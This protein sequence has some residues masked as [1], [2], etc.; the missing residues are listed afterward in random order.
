[1]HTSLWT[2]IRLLAW[3]EG[4][5]RS[6]DIDSPRLT[7]EILLSHV[8]NIR[9]L[10]LYLQFDRP[11]STNEL[12]LYKALIK[13]RVEK[14]PV[15]YITGVKG[16]WNSQFFVTPDV[17]IPRPDTETLVESA[18]ALVEQ[19][20]QAM[21]DTVGVQDNSGKLISMLGKDIYGEKRL[22][23][24]ELGTGSGAVII[25]LAMANPDVLFYATDISPDATAVAL[26]NSINL[27]VSNDV[28]ASNAASISSDLSPSD[29][30][31]KLSSV[32]VPVERVGLANLFFLSGSWFLPIK[33]GVCFDLI[34][35]NPPYIPTSDIKNLQQEV[36]EYE[37]VLALDGGVEGISCLKE[38]LEAAPDYLESDG[39]LLI[40]MGFDQKQRLEHEVVSI[41]KYDKPVF[42]KDYAGHHRVVSLQKK[43]KN[44]ENKNKI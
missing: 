37:P 33:K 6:F 43:I 21:K 29:D 36:R 12:A 15:A 42:I 39:F 3:T 24:L 38:I 23:V 4:Y 26:K 22:K 18:L 8:L 13:R 14:E 1:M 11:L 16:F 35:S 41:S 31:L 44:I 7:A 30:S 17:L 20:K 34:V 27:S 32:D 25:S 10:D 5:F 9:R 19:K 2:I 40:E 28:S